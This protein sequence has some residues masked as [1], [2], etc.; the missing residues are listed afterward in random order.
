M[1]KTT[2]RYTDSEPMF[3][4]LLARVPAETKRHHDL[5][6]E[7]GCRIEEILKRKGW[8]QSDLAKAMGKRESEISKWLGGGHNF[9]ISTIINIETALETD[10]LS[11]KK[12]RKPLSGFETTEENRNRRL[13]YDKKKPRKTTL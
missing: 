3:D 8:T 12:Y 7:I 1:S 5:L 6:T 10:I 13:S 11:V 2:T 4:E 9:T